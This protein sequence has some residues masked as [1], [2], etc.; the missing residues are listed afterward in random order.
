MNMFDLTELET[1]AAVTLVQCCLDGMGGKRPS[2]L[3]DD[4]YTWADPVDLVSQMGISRHQSAGLFSSLS[5]KGFICDYGEDDSSQK[6]N[7]YVTT[8]GWRWVDTIWDGYI[9]LNGA[10]A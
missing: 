10:T 2:D 4:E 5:N 1:K 6:Y 8:A 7:W 3:E 9:A